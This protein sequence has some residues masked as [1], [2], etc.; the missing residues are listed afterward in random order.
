MRIKSYDEL[1]DSGY[2][3]KLVSSLRHDLGY[4]T[5]PDSRINLNIINLIAGG[6]FKITRVVDNKLE[7]LGIDPNHRDLHYTLISPG[8]VDG[9]PFR[10][11]GGGS[12][13]DDSSF[14]IKLKEAAQRKIRKIR[15]DLIIKKL[16]EESSK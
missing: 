12:P 10:L 16:K 3:K 15:N 9:N 11:L 7:I 5:Y 6:V 14:I 8:V 1:L 13:L 4:V 2:V